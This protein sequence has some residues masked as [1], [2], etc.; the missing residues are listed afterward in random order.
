MD[1]SRNLSLCSTTPTARNCPSNPPNHLQFIHSIPL[2]QNPHPFVVLRTSQSVVHGRKPRAPSASKRADP[3]HLVE[4]P[5]AAPSVLARR[6]PCCARPSPWR[7]RAGGPPGPGAPASHA[8]DAGGVAPNG[9]EQRSFYGF[10][11]TFIRNREAM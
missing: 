4:F 5:V 11:H 1:A 3:S 6:R 8:T 9:D 7:G 10:K 2:R